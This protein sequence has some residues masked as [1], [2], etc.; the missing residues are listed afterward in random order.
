MKPTEGVEIWIIGIDTFEDD[1]PG[2]NSRTMARGEV[3]G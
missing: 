3:W 2:H 1:I